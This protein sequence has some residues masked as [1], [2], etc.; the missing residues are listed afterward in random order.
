[1]SA[2]IRQQYNE[3]VETLS[4]INMQ[5]DGL[6]DLLMNNQNIPQARLTD[7]RAKIGHLK[8]EQRRLRI[9]RK[10]ILNSVFDIVEGVDHERQ[11]ESAIRHLKAIENVDKANTQLRTHK[12]LRNVD[13]KLRQDA[14]AA[15]LREVW[16]TETFP[17]FKAICELDDDTPIICA[18]YY[19]RLAL[20]EYA[21][22][23]KRLRNDSSVD[24]PFPQFQQWP[25]DVPLSVSVNDINMMVQKI[26]VKYEKRTASYDRLLSK[27]ESCFKPSV[28]VGTTKTVGITI[29]KKRT[30]AK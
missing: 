27:I 21:E 30:T 17:I 9:K 8:S 29:K 16:C 23:N 15:T 14:M 3:L 1:M 6:F 25:C 10:E 28:V 18:K 24:C 4:S 22:L 26:T 19:A 2:S 7:I 13:N 5:L 12:V 11:T 20:Y